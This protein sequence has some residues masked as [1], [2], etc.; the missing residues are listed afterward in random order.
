[1]DDLILHLCKFCQDDCDCV[2]TEE[3]P[4]CSGCKCCQLDLEIDDYW[5]ND[6]ED[7]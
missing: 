6:N 7:L 2:Y 5:E 4:W 3:D 1:M